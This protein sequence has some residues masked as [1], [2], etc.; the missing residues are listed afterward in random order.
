MTKEEL[1]IYRQERYK[2]NKEKYK[3]EYQN[4]K[5]KI[6]EYS[7]QYY[8]N[9]K[10]KILEYQKKYCEKNKEKRIIIMKKINK[11]NYENNKEKRK[12]CTL[13]YI[14]KRRKIDPL[15]RLTCNLR[16]R[17]YMALKIDNYT[18]QTNTFKILGCDLDT[19]KL[20]IEEKFTNGMTWENKGKWHIDHIVP[21]SSAKTEEEAYQ[22]C[23]YTNLQPLWAEDNMNKGIKI[24]G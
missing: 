4:N 10:E 23:H 21:L 20:H 14:N 5:E 13:V 19:I 6:K 15:F 3:L 11:K 7:K 8:E 9:N 1:K 17:I 18:K 2:K 24:N 16:S 12:K 22:L